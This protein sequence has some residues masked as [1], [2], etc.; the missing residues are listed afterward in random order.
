MDEIGRSGHAS[1]FEVAINDGDSRSPEQW[2]RAVFEGGPAAVQSFVEL[3]WRYVLGLRLGPRSSP[4]HVSGW[5]VRNAGPDAISLDVH[6]WLLTAT[7]DIR[8]ANGTVRVGTVIRYER[9]LG[10]LVW[11]LVTPVHFL[12]EPYL[13]GYAASHRD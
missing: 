3:G 2:A 5:T 13:L 1:A 4:D 6:S 9:R 8:V 10:R 7:K 12:A 11:T